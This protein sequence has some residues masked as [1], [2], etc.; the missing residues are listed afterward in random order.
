MKAQNRTKWRPIPWTED[1]LHEVSTTLLDTVWDRQTCSWVAD[2]ISLAWPLQVG[3]TPKANNKTKTCWLHQQT[4]S[5]SDNF[6][7][8]VSW[9]LLFV[10]ACFARP[11][12]ISNPLW[13]YHAAPY[14]AG[15]FSC[16][17][18]F[19]RGAAAARDASA[20]VR[21][22]ACRQLAKALGAPHGAEAGHERSVGVGVGGW[23]GVRGGTASLA[24]IRY[25]GLTV[26]G[27]SSDDLF[28][29]TLEPRLHCPHRTQVARCCCSWG[30]FKSRARHHNP[31]RCL[32]FLLRPFLIPKGGRGPKSAWPIWYPFRGDWRPVTAQRQPI[33]LSPEVF[34]KADPPRRSHFFFVRNQLSLGRHPQQPKGS[35][36][37]PP[38]RVRRFRFG[39]AGKTKGFLVMVCLFHCLWDKQTAPLVET[40][41]KG[42]WSFQWSQWL[43]ASRCFPSSNS[44]SVRDLLRAGGAHERALGNP[45]GRPSGSLGLGRMRVAK[46][47]ELVGWFVVF[48]AFF[49]RGVRQI[50]WGP[51]GKLKGQGSVFV[52]PGWALYLVPLE[53]Q[54]L[55]PDPSLD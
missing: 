26:W 37:Q 32:G 50:F 11:Q 3:F 46:N 7:P 34:R 8:R 40:L 29:D 35:P 52:G 13:A 41:F 6:R 45:A 20:A 1:I 9:F 55:A 2:D 21:L 42:G 54:F 25:L 15:G 38:A 49:L 43:R 36:E 12:K 10:S 16:C 18:R 48:H 5:P 28:P 27:R 22:G 24:L 14:A 44:C 4:Y 33:P 53:S 30:S 39:E 47:V 51:C 19:P 23:S 17:G 31:S